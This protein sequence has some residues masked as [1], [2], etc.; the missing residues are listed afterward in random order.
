MSGPPVKPITALSQVLAFD[1]SHEDDDEREE[2]EEDSTS[3]S[4]H[5][6][7]RADEGN[8]SLANTS[9]AGTEMPRLGRRMPRR[10]PRPSITTRGR[11]LPRRSIAGARGAAQKKKSQLIALAASEASLAAAKM[12]IKLLEVEAKRRRLGSERAGRPVPKSTPAFETNNADSVEMSSWCRSFVSDTQNRAERAHSA[13]PLALEPMQDFIIEQF[14]DSAA[15]RS[16]SDSVSVTDSVSSARSHASRRDNTAQDS[17]TAPQPAA[18]QQQQPPRS[19]RQRIAR[20]FGNN[21]DSSAPSLA[22]TTTMQTQ[23]APQATMRLRNEAASPPP[24]RQHVE[25]LPSRPTDT[26]IERSAPVAVPQ[27]RTAAAN[28]APAPADQT[29]TTT[30]NS[31]PPAVAA[32]R[33]ARASSTSVAVAQARLVK[34]YSALAAAVQVPLATPLADRQ[35]HQGRGDSAVSIDSLLD[36]RVELT[37]AASVRQCICAGSPTRRA[38]ALEAHE[39]A[40]RRVPWRRLLCLR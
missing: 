4:S 8:T 19:K 25:S 1:V 9:H 5:T 38:Q 17:L 32:L 33:T 37:A 13:E 15:L 39:C 29:R 27:A 30:T 20:Y 22:L 18:Q 2:D 21:G 3:V 31:A 28:T 16:P 10:M 6:P 36:L 14:R 26:T 12:R 35:S 11:A 7:Q 24:A 40:T 23:Q 34:T